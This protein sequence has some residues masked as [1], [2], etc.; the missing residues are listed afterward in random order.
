[1]TVAQLRRSRA[2]IPLSPRALLRWLL[3]KPLM[4]LPENILLSLIARTSIF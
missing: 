3:L 4:L 2:L 1:M